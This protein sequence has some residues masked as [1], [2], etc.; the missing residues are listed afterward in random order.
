MPTIANLSVGIGGDT[1]QLDAAV[2]NAKKDIADL[3]NATAAPKKDRLG[4]IA[5]FATGAVTAKLTENSSSVKGW[6]ATIG[7]AIGAAF[8]GIGAPIG[9]ALGG[10]LGQ[11]IE[12]GEKAWG[13]ITSAVA[14]IGEAF[15]ETFGAISEQFRAAFSSVG[16]I[17]SPV[18]EKISAGI[19]AVGEMLSAF[20]AP[21]IKFVAEAFEGVAFVAV[22]TF[23]AIA[24]AISPVWEWLKKL[25]AQWL[26]LSA[27]WPNGGEIAI[28]ALG[29]IGKGVG[30]VIDAFRWL[31]GAVAIGIG[32]IVEW[33]GPPLLKALGGVIEIIRV[34]GRTGTQAIGYIVDAFKWLQG[35]ALV[36]V[37]KVVENLGEPIFN[38]CKRVAE[39]LAKVLPDSFGG[40]FLKSASDELDMLAR[41]AKK[42][43]QDV[44]KE[45]REAMGHFG[46][47]AQKFAQKFDAGIGAAF[48]RASVKVFL[49]GDEARKQGQGIAG[50][51]QKQMAAF[52]DTAAAIGGFFDDVLA[53]FRGRDRQEEE[54]EKEQERGKKKPNRAVEIGTKEAFEIIHGAQGDKMYTVANKQL[55]ELIK[56]VQ[57]LQDAARKKMKGGVPLV[58]RGKL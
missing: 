16:K 56:M 32:K 46:D 48:E 21:I 20:L 57:L 23:N 39:A 10:A 9:A 4:S 17:F 5:S 35:A 18:V 51:G 3:Q 34:L 2:G 50:W 44:A 27:A 7:G 11:L 28:K 6:A 19:K 22:E 37:G 13:A 36:A 31:A 12:W 26:N 25:L 43:G 24:A 30:Y 40:N 29:A 42:A 55:A 14:P 47:E 53:K 49:L 45:G 33:L 15:S 1:A 52:G 8:G 58:Q 38:A 54:Q 41:N